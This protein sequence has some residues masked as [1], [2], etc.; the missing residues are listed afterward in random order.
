M[1]RL[2]RYTQKIFGSIAGTNQIAEFGS[3]AAGSPQR[4]T[5]ATITPT[6]VQALSNYL[7]GWFAAVEGSYSPAIED[8]NA[9]CYLYAFQL[10]YLMQ[11][12]VAEW[13]SGTTYYTGSLAQSSGVTYV[14]LTDTN[15]NNPVTDS[16]NWFSPTQP[17]LLTSNAVPFTAG[18]TLPAN[19][20]MMWPNMQIGNGQT[21]IVPSGA[22]LIGFEQIVVSGS[23][24]LQATG[25]GVIKIY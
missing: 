3:F 6:I 9:L 13:D 1:S 20:T 21:V 2:S 5:G 17:G 24:I 14:S 7:S 18:M 11:Q 15:L 19:K 10:A 12:G 22:K 8:M 25:T 23:G 16:G 4:Y